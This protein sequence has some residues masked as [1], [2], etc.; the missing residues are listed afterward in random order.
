LIAFAL[1]LKPI[2]RRPSVQQ[3]EK[4]R[5]G[6]LKLAQ[7]RTFIMLSWLAGFFI[8]IWVLGFINSAPLLTFLYLKF[9]AREKWITSVALAAVSWI[10]FYS[11]FVYAIQLPFP[12]GI[13][14]D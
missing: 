9:G 12:P 4:Q 14:F 3:V 2:L 7:W 8:G 11:L 10:F 1:A 5:D 13:I 6:K